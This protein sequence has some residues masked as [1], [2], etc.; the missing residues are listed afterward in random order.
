VNRPLPKKAAAS[1]RRL[2]VE[3]LKDK[4]YRI[5]SDGQRYLN[6]KDIRVKHI[7]EDLVD[8]I[9]H[10]H[11]FELPIQK[12]IIEDL[13]DKIEHYHIFELP[14]QSGTKPQKGKATPRQKYQYVIEYK[15]PT[16]HV[17]VKMT[18]DAED[19][20]TVFLGFHSHNTGFAPLPQIPT[21][22]NSTQT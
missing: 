5:Y 12:H 1:I 6:I 21:D 3:C 9:E 2:I 20:P 10:Y 15:N 22:Q 4:R 16:L 8:E 14:I 19:P 18:P 13:V 11:I 7:I 17:H